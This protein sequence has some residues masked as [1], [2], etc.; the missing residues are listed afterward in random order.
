MA[1]KVYIVLRAMPWH[2]L[3]VAI[4]QDEDGNTH[5]VAAAGDDNNAGFLPVY[6][7]EEAAREAYPDAQIKAG[8]V[9]DSWG[10]QEAPQGAQSMTLDMDSLDRPALL[11]LAKDTEKTLTEDA[12]QVA[13]D[14]VLKGKA[15]T[16]RLGKRKLRGYIACLRGQAA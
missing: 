6:W 2:N 1:K 5:T 12:V 11:A 13:R 15:P 7:S 4:G 3:N 10:Q 14:A 8:E 9:G 16:A